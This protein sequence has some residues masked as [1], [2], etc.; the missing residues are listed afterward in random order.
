[1]SQKLIQVA[2]NKVENNSFEQKVRSIDWSKYLAPEYYDPE[3]MFYDPARP[4]KALIQ[5]NQ[6]D[7]SK[8]ESDAGISS[9]V[10]YAIGNDHRGTYYPAALEAIDLIIEIEKCSDKEAARNCAKYILNDL[11]YFQLELG[12]KDKNLYDSIN[13][14]VREKLKSYSDENL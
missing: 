1:M 14:V 7:E 6:F 2:G 10:R 8:A 11:Y 3:M 5:L 13:G 9:E 12:S 4:V